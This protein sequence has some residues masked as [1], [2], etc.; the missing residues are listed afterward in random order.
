MTPGAMPFV[1]CYAIP[2]AMLIVSRRAGE[3]GQCHTARF[4]FVN[5]AGETRCLACDSDSEE[6]RTWLMEMAHGCP[7]A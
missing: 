6:I 7:L 1:E 2:G 3:C 4:L 5:R